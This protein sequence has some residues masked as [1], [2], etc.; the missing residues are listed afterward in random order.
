MTDKHP[1]DV[2]IEH[3]AGEY[4]FWDE[5]GVDR[6]GPYKSRQEARDKLK[7][8]AE[9]VLGDICEWV[10]YDGWNAPCH[11][12]QPP[13][14]LPDICPHCKKPVVGDGTDFGDMD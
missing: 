4:W 8:Y 9:E 11:A 1:D 13:M 3:F 14:E 10:Y 2:H 5:A 7:K 6:Y 12:N